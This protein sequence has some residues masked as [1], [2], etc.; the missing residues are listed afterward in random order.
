VQT[1]LDT[2][3]HRFILANLVAK[4]FKTLYRSMALGLFWALLQPLFLVAVLSVVFVFFYKQV[5]F[6]SFVIVCL[7]PYNFISYTVSASANVILSNQGLVKKVRFPR[8]IL[9]ISVVATHAI[10]FAI[11]SILIL[12]V[13][14][15]F[16][17][18]AHVLGIQLLWLPVIVVVHLGLA[19]G[20]SLLVSGTNVVYRDVHYL[21]DSLMTLLFWLSPI[22]YDARSFLLIPG[23]HAYVAGI[24]DALRYGYYLNPLAG[25]LEAYRGVLY[26]GRAPDALTFGMATGVTLLVG[27]WG[28]RSFWIHERAFA[29]LV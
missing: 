24:P 28:V 25:I 16:P 21:V 14:L 8:Q 20:L 27:A 3:R 10:H 13:L 29:D 9:P 11:Q 18:H 6:P 12:G 5:D 4:E 2:Y 22:L 23:G 1:F 7:I 15:L 26:D 19:V 17:P